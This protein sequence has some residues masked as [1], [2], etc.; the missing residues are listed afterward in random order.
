MSLALIIALLLFVYLLVPTYERPRVLP[1]LVSEDERK[2]IMEKARPDL[3]PS[4][5]AQDRV[6][7]TKN[8]VSETAWLDNNDPVISEVVSRCM[9]HVDRP[10][11]N[12]ENLQVLRYGEGGFYN[13]HHDSLGGNNQRM[14]TFIVCLNDDFEGGETK[15]PNINK[16]YRLR[17]GDVLLFDCLNNYEFKDFRAIHGGLPV[18]SGE[19]WICN[20]WV[21]KYEYTP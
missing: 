19:K 12:C 18:T 6:L 3:R 7:D 9:K 20:L 10:V 15:F 21:H 2:Y 5:V 8:R 14:Y 16:S 4:T 1:G 11:R 13:F 17:A